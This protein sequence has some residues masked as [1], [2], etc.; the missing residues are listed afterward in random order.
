MYLPANSV[1]ALGAL[2]LQAA[3]FGRAWVITGQRFLDHRGRNGHSA[4]KIAAR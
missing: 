2:G 4:R 3:L 1:R